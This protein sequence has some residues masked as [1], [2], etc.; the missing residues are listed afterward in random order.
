[1]ICC[2][3]GF[4]G[5]CCWLRPSRDPVPRGRLGRRRVDAGLWLS[6]ALGSRLGV[7]GEGGGGDPRARDEEVKGGA[8]GWGGRGDSDFGFGGGRGSA[9]GAGR[10]GRFGWVR[11]WACA[12]RGGRGGG[13]GSA[14]AEPRTW[15]RVLARA[16]RSSGGVDA[17]PVVPPRRLVM[18]S[19]W[20]LLDGRRV[21]AE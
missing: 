14:A 19:R 16:G 3:R 20:R 12:L 5:A 4:S 21:E 2:D 13:G 6:W 9:E 7:E 8:G 1:M 15:R 18:A 10:R 17:P 11:S